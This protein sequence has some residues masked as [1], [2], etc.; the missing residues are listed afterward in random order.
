[1]P[2]WY[3]AAIS[4]FL[5][6]PHT[7]KSWWRKRRHWAIKRSRSPM[8]ARSA[9]VVRAYQAQRDYPQLSLIIGSRFRLHALDVVLLCPTQAAY[10]ELCRLSPMRGGAVTK[11]ITS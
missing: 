3:V 10:Q 4:P 8:N 9:G 2:S 11:A 7:R 5:R 6:A 1:M